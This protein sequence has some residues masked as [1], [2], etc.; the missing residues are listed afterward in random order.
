MKTLI[1]STVLCALLT[2]CGEAPPP[3]EHASTAAADTIKAQVVAEP[4]PDPDAIP[5]TVDNFCRAE[6][7]M[8]FGA[9]I[10]KWG[11]G[12][13]GHERDAVPADKQEVVR[14]NRDTYYSSAVVD[15]EAGPVTI[16]MPDAKGRFQ[17]VLAI[18]E[19]HYIAGITYIPG[20]HTFTRDK[21]GTRY[22]AF[23]VRTFVDPNDPEDVEQAHA[24]QDG[25]KM[26]QPGGPGRFEVPKWDMVSQKKVREAL[27][28]LGSTL[29]GF[30]HAFGARGA[31]DPIRHLI[32][33]ASAWGGNPD[34]DARYDS[35]TPEH[36][37]GKTAYVLHVKD[38]PV[39]G[40]WSI[41]VYNSKGFYEAPE[42]S[43][44]VNNLT[45]KKDPDGGIAI[46]FGGDPS[47]PNYLHIMDGWNYTV[48]M[49][50]PRKE[51]LDGTWT[52]PE[53]QPVN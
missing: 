45:A 10:K 52:F 35:N 31:V 53:A 26:S 43:V 34:K 28:V 51:I 1:T 48:R 11:L 47:Q 41:T 18:D 44:S 21:V 4:M 16:A 30:H 15:L 24:L 9:I 40:F 14:L 22:L 37:D 32:A 39:D 3:V 36:N 38:V 13:M 27:D 6:T 19:D 33:T 46:H 5:V 8:Y 17:S 49:Y 42:N 12:I 2:A 29:Q 7:D 23:A 25:I 20:P 50:R